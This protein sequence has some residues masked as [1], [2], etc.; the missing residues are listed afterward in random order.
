MAVFEQLRLWMDP[1]S[2]AGP[3]AMAVDEWLLETAVTPVLRV[4][5]WRGNWGSIGYFGKLAEAQAA[6]AQI[7][8]VRRWTGGGTVD[9]R[10]DWT[11]TV[12]APA[13]GKLAGARGSESYRLLH[14]AVAA[15]LRAERIDSRLSSG[16]EQTGAALCFENPVS[17]DLVDAGGRKLAG[18]GQRRTRHGLLHQ[19]SV[20]VPCESIISQERGERLASVLA[21]M[22]RIDDFHPPQAIIAQKIGTRYGCGK[23]TTRC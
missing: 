10:A 6:F 22:W 21:D 19:G 9:H 12:I 20:A 23:W 3:E 14:S 2:R 11:Y 1:V 4:Y 15:A 7:D 16:A 17:H 8:W 18:A 5:G 13:G